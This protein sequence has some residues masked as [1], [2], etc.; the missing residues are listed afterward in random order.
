MRKYRKQQSGEAM[1]VD[2]DTED[3][4]LACC[5][6]GKVHTVQF[7][8]I[9]DNIWDFAFFADNRATGQLRRH[10]YG[11]LHNKQGFIGDNMKDNLD[12]LDHEYVCLP[13]KLVYMVYGSLLRC[14]FC[15]RKLKLVKNK[16]VEELLK[17][18]G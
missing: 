10:K 18:W 5:A 13:C 14:D 17:E 2:L 9:K 8:H 1:L 4:K 12:I 6:C 7:H 3:L 16:K 11:N 15:G